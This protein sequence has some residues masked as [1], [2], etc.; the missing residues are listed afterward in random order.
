MF[1]HIFISKLKEISRNKSSIGW[2]LVFPIMLATAFYIGFGNTIK[3]TESISTV[4]VAVVEESEGYFTDMLENISEEKEDLLNITYAENYD[5]AGDL[6]QNG[7]VDGIYIIN[8]EDIRMEV[9]ESDIHSTVLSSILKS[10]INYRGIIEDIIEEETHLLMAGEISQE[11][12]DEKIN[13]LTAYFEDDTAVIE[14]YAFKENPISPYMSYFFALVAMACLY[15]SWLSS[16]IISGIA[17]TGSEQGKRLGVSPVS[18]FTIILASSLAGLIVQGICNLLLVFFIEYVLGFTFGKNLLYILLAVLGASLTGITSGV[19]IGAI[20]AGKESIT[21]G[22]ALAYSMTCSFLSGL[23]VGNM[24]AVI[25]QNAPIINRINPAALLT[26][27]LYSAGTYGIGKDYYVSV[28]IL[29]VESLV[30]MIIAGILL[31][32]RDYDYV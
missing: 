2:N 9:T 25:E 16:D 30:F 4:S 15:G 19:L 10:Y 23:M 12:F 24:K 21:T 28:L 6:L 26:E 17:P 7:K 31:R 14:P 32:R 22:V 8:G 20:F 18:K 13:S 27:A 11:E 29:F 1:W 5:Q 3:G